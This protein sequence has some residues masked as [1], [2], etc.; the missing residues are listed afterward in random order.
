VLTLISAAQLPNRSVC[1]WAA[2]LC[3]LTAVACGAAPRGD[4]DATASAAVQASP[5]TV[6]HLEPR[7]DSVGPRPARFA[8]TTIEGADSYT[9]HLWNEVDMKLL[10]QRGVTA[11][12]VAWPEELDL[13][14]GTYFWAVIAMREGRPIAESGLSAFVITE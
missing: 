9:L 3:V 7:R 1:S 2:V 5:P 10:E 11:T 4:A 6:D 12:T 14:F 13:P 8:W